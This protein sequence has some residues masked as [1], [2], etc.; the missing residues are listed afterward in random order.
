MVPLLM[1]M[2]VGFFEG[3]DSII[4]GN[5]LR[6]HPSEILHLC[7]SQLNLE[8]LNLSEHCGLNGY[9]KQNLGNVIF[10]AADFFL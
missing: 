4:L 5:H 1:L 3:D 2:I 6:A 7:G 8:C 10:G 9:L